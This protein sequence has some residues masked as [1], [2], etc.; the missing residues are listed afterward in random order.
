MNGTHYIICVINIFIMHNGI[1]NSNYKAHTILNEYKI[2]KI[3]K[4]YK[5]A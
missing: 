5:K 2:L 3:V 1:I 4:T